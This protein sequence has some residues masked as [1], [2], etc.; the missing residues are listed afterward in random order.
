MMNSENTLFDA[1]N[2]LSEEISEGIS[3]ITNCTTSSKKAKLQEELE[4]MRT[5]SYSVRPSPE[6][7]YAT[8][9]FRKYADEANLIK[10]QNPQWID[11]SE[12][13]EKLPTFVTETNANQL[14]GWSA[15]RQHIFWLRLLLAI[16]S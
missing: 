4:M 12:Y 10:D 7:A 11:V 5:A 6:V 16:F 14:V 2:R 3:N 15:L 9:L 13:T 8:S 1:L